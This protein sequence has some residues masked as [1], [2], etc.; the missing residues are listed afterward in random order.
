MLGSNQISLKE[1]TIF[2]DYKNVFL[3]SVNALE[4]RSFLSIILDATFSGTQAA[5]P[6]LIIHHLVPGH[7]D[8]LSN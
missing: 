3:I 1:I 5:A 7:T 2:I 6:S 4:T 8:V